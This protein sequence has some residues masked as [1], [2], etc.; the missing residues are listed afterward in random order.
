MKLQQMYVACESRN[1]YNPAVDIGVEAKNYSWAMQNSTRPL[2]YLRPVKP[3]L[4]SFTLPSSCLPPS[5]FIVG[6]SCAC[7]DAYIHYRLPFTV[8]LRKNVFIFI[9]D[10]QLMSLS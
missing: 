3:S 5:F 4:L 10:E 9:D 7:G 2:H 8:C 1:L 6:T